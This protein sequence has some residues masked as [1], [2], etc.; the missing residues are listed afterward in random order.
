MRRDV[1]S[2]IHIVGT[3]EC[4]LAPRSGQKWAHVAIEDSA[5]SMSAL[6]GASNLAKRRLRALSNALLGLPPS[7]SQNCIEDRTNGHSQFRI[8]GEQLLN[9]S[10]VFTSKGCETHVISI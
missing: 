6:N 1:R 9:Q 2:S 8:S 5:P 4:G 10:E 3:F 7:V